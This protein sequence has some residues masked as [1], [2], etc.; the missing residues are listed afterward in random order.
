MASVHALR[1]CHR[2][3]VRLLGFIVVRLCLL[4]TQRGRGLRDVDFAHVLEHLL[5]VD[6]VTHAGVVTVI[7]T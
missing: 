3:I 2:L 6:T 5:D 7:H 1:S 4:L